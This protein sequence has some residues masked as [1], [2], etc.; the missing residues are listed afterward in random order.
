MPIRSTNTA[1]SGKTTAK[2]AGAGGGSPPV[3]VIKNRLLVVDDE[4]SI[5]EVMRV[6]FSASMPDCR[7][8]LAVNGAE[9]LNMFRDVHHGVIVMDVRM[10][11][12][13]GQ[14]AF[15]EIVEHCR[16]MGWEMPRI[17]FCT[18]F[19]PSAELRDVL[20]K[21]GLHYLIKKPFDATLL[22]KAIRGE[23]QSAAVNAAFA[24]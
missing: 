7:V 12:M 16:S 14:T 9:A 11:V 17:I 24:S 6:I 19:Q 3:P 10:P 1:K 22:L 21:N 23:L 2:D 13:D 5:R 4:Q 18:G 20:S 15:F 8:D